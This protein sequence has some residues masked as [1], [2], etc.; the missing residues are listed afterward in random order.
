MH[1]SLQQTVQH[2]TDVQLLQVQHKH[3]L[4]VTQCVRSASQVNAQ[5]PFPILSMPNTWQ[6]FSSGLHDSSFSVRVCMPRVCDS[7]VAE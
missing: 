2:E 5:R 3:K 1:R 7:A 4:K 6:D